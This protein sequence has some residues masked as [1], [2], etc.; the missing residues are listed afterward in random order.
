MLNFTANEI[1][2]IRNILTGSEITQ[3]DFENGIATPVM[4]VGTFTQVTNFGDNLLID[5]S[6]LLAGGVILTEDGFYPSLQRM[7]CSKVSPEIT[8]IATLLE[9]VIER[10]EKGGIMSFNMFVDVNRTLIGYEITPNL[11]DGTYLYCIDVPFNELYRWKGLAFTTL[12]DLGKEVDRMIPVDFLRSNGV[13]S[14]DGLFLDF[15]SAR[16]LL[17]KLTFL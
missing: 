14:P 2:G 7:F 12:F 9:G 4:R 5:N 15:C 1:L 3:V 16:T 8:R 6:K 17:T 10:F 11:I 13:I